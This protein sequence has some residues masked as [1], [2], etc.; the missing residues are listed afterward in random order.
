VPEK[1]NLQLKEGQTETRSQGGKAEKKGGGHIVSPPQLFKEK[2]R[3]NSVEHK[4]L[5]C[6]VSFQGEKG[7][8]RGE[9]KIQVRRDLRE[10]R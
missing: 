8:N 3:E 1:K 9:R 4:E 10:R 6:H 7:G 5:N 2:I